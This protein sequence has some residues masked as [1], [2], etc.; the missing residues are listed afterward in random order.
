MD[1]PH[2]VKLKETSE[3]LFH[4]VSRELISAIQIEIEDCFYKGR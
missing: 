4:Y 2:N 3:E 1:N